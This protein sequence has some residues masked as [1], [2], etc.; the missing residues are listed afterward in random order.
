MGGQEQGPETL[1]EFSRFIRKHGNLNLAWQSVRANSRYSTSPY[2]QDEAQNFAG[3]EQRRIKSIGARLQ[4]AT[5]KFA[6]S[7]GVAIT[8]TGKPGAVR[9]IVIARVEDRIVQRCILDALTSD[10]R[11]KDR[12]FQPNSFGGIPKRGKDERAGVVAA[13]ERLFE[14]VA[15]GATHVIVADIKGFFQHIRK[16]EC[17]KI[18]REYVIDQRFLNTLGD[19]IAVDLE[20]AR[21]LWRHKDEF[22]YGDVGIAQGNCLSPFL[23]NLLLSDFDRRMNE[24]DCSCLRYIDDIIILAPSG[25]A[26]SARL[27]LAR[28]ILD[29]HGMELSESKT[30]AVPIQV[31]ETFEYLGIE[32]CNRRLRP[33]AK[34]QKSIE[35]RVA[36]VAAKS[37]GRMRSCTD[38]TLF[39]A[40]FNVPKTLNRIAGMAK[41]WSHHYAFCSDKT[42]VLAV[43]HKICSLYMEYLTRAQEVAKGKVPPV[44]AMLL[45][46]RGAA[47]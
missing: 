18:I 40:N 9:P 26:A 30:S 7:R 3:D 35:S 22:P 45:G 16:S 1:D 29:R 20:N 41:G 8:K 37:L 27:R 38:A 36:E 28:K 10:Q 44:R 4:F 46:Y 25:R 11:I 15:N 32:F 12:A 14:C 24:G 34:A 21:A 6:K 13:I 19:A 17:L 39:D 43:D 42:S 31:T 5:Y 47:K 2:V 23:G 33:A